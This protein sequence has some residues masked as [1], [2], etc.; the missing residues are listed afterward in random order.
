VWNDWA[1]EVFGPYNDLMSPLAAIM[2]ADV[3]IA[4]EEIKRTARR[5]FRGFTLPAKP[6]WGAHDSRHPNYNLDMYDPMW[7][8]IQDLDLPITFHV[9]TGMDPRT[10]RREGGA[11]I[12]YVANA[13]T[14][15]IEPMACLCASGVFERFPKLRFALIE[16][17]IGWV[18]WALDAM[19]EAYRKHHL[20]AYPKLKQLPSEYFRQHGAVTFQEDRAGLMQAE[21]FNRSTTLC[22]PMTIRTR[23]EPGRIRPAVIARPALGGWPAGGGAEPHQSIDGLP[24]PAY[25]PPLARLANE[26]RRD[27]ECERTP[28]SRAGNQ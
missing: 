5:G 26:G 2:T 9:S 1:W 19:D 15:V 4:I 10:A 8:V 11:V 20:W 3:Q 21:P 13:C 18:P 28:N 22:G 6:I 23:K 7:A 27:G 17:G 16:C 25:I 14:Q 24:G 12:N